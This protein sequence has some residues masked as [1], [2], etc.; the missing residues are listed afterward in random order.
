[1]EKI[2]IIETESCPDQI[3]IPAENPPKMNVSGFVGFLK[4]KSSL[5]IHKRH[6]NLKYKYGNK[7]F[8]CRGYYVDTTGKARKELR[9]TSKINGKKSKYRTR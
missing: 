1:M 8:W 3:H 4:S 7:V 2:N 5:L 9:N 6:G